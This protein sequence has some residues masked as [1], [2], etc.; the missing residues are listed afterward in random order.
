MSSRSERGEVSIPVVILSALLI[1]IVGLILAFLVS[2]WKAEGASTQ[3]T[4]VA[5]QADATKQAQDQVDQLAQQTDLSTQQALD[6]AFQGTQQSLLE[7]IQGTQAALTQQAQVIMTVEGQSNSA[8]QTSQTSDI[9]AR[10]KSAK[11]LLYEGTDELNAGM[12]VQTAL[13]G[14]GLKYKQEGSYSGRF[15]QDLNSSE[16]YDLIIV[17]AEDHQAITGEFWDV[18]NTRVIRDKTALIVEMWYLDQEAY[19]PIYYILSDCGIAYTKDWTTLESIY[20]WEPAHEIFNTPNVVPPLIHFNPFWPAGFGDRVRL[21]SGGD[22]TLL[23]GPSSTKSNDAVLATCN[24][25]R[26]IWQFFND[27]DFP[28]GQMVPL[29]QNYITYTLKNHFA[30]TSP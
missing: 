14:L 11:I 1:L 12:I 28:R 26:Q 5:L 18:I 27:H 24:G 15:M 25:G 3:A 16:I 17:D 2:K 10:I 9:E 21:A 6:L 7:S 23:A 22:A 4:L 19:G 13:D 8:G 30:A 29:W 20:W